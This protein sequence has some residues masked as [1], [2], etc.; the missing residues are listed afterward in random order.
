MMKLFSG[1]NP[2]RLLQIFLGLWLL[3]FF[4]AGALCADYEVVIHKNNQE[5]IVKE[6]GRIVRTFRVATGKGGNGAKRQ[7]GDKK[8]PIGVYKVMNFKA[9]SK[10]YFF[11]QL[12]YPNLID[13]WYGYKNEVITAAE[14]KKIASAY[15][16]KQ[17]PPQDTALGGQIG[18][19]GLGDVTEQKLSIHQGY[20]WTEGCIALTNDQIND[21][22]KYV[23]IGTQ[24]VI[25]E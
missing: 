15:K 6:G 21:L 14:F 18:I 22:R 19:H 11:M 12:N 8:T 10:F 24:V 2:H 13:A 4:P 16:N 23:K 5:L 20:N 9:N 17:M 25:R 7:L 3:Q 1:A